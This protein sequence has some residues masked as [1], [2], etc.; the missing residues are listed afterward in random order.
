MP[1]S[2][3]IYIIHGGGLEEPLEES[4]RFSKFASRKLQTCLKFNAAQF[5]QLNLHF[6]FVLVIVFVVFFSISAFIF[7]FDFIFVFVFKETAI[8]PKIQFFGGRE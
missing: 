1:V 2:G 6:V 7:A 5:H 8:L 4:P 3:G